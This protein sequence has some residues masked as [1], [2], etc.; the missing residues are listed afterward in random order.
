MFGKHLIPYFGGHYLPT[1]TRK[2][3][4]D[5]TAERKQEANVATINRELAALKEIFR[6]AVEWDYL[7]QNPAAGIKQFKKQPPAPRYLEVEEATALLEMCPQRSYAFVATAVNTQVR[8][9][10][11]FYLEWSNIDFRKR[12]ITVQNK[13]AFHT[14]N[15]E[16]RFIPMND[17]LYEVLR[18]HPRHISSPNVFCNPDATEIPDIRTSSENALKKAGLPHIRIHDLRHTFASHLVMAGVDLPTVQELM[19]H[20]TIQTTMRYAHL[21][22]GHLK[23]AVQRLSF[24]S[25]REH[26]EGGMD[27]K[28]TPRLQSKK[29]HLSENRLSA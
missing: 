27:T 11:L 15:Y 25:Q 20:K 6:K 18:K 4:E 17:F 13:E 26:R 16:P 10:E 29:K 19:G 3:I 8:K 9:S 14:K 21:A 28:W 23:A 24:C 22:P 2:M 5:Y 1:I 7:K 12:L